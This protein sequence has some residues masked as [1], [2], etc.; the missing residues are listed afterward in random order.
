[1]APILK[2]MEV[3]QRTQQADQKTSMV[4]CT[5]NLF[6]ISEAQAQVLFRATHLKKCLLQGL[7]HM[8]YLQTLEIQSNWCCI[9]FAFYIC[10]SAQVKHEIR[11]ECWIGGP[12]KGRFIYESWIRTLDHHDKAHGIMIFELRRVKIFS[13]VGILT[14][15]KRNLDWWCHAKV[16]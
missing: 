3:R 14:A 12:E 8:M 9:K 15:G 7:W 2:I 1:M 13:N 5:N 16:S 6:G 4:G 10:T 11:N